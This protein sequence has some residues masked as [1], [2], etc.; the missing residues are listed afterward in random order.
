MWIII[1]HYLL[2]GLQIKTNW[3]IKNTFFVAYTIHLNNLVSLILTSNYAHL[4]MI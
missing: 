3:F 4:I 1:Y 2:I